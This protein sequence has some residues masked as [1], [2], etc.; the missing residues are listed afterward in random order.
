[1]KNSLLIFLA[2]LVYQTYNVNKLSSENSD[3]KRDKK[4]LLSQIQKANDQILEWNRSYLAQDFVK[5]NNLTKLE[6]LTGEQE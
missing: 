3:L 6:Y 1:M 2:L 4:H 5:K